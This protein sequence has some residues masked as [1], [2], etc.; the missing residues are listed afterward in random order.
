L[1]RLRPVRAPI[2]LPGAD[3]ASAAAVGQRLRRAVSEQPFALGDG[4]KVRGRGAPPCDV[5]RNPMSHH[6][7][8][9]QGSIPDAIRAAIEDKVEGSKAEVQGGGDHHQIVVTAAVFAG[10]STL[11][12]QRLV[13]S[14][15]THLM[16]RDAAPVHAVD[17]LITKTP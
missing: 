6:L 9:F 17:S 1:L 12:R 11:E 3:R 15:I 7:T 10:K 14:A 5:L 16:Q 4:R 13:Y 2:L 8:T